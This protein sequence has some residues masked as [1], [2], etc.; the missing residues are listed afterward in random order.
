MLGRICSV[1]GLILLAGCVKHGSTYQFDPSAIRGEAEQAPPEEAPVPP[2][3]KLAAQ[4]E[5]DPPVKRRRSPPPKDEPLPDFEVKGNEGAEWL[6]A[7]LPQCEIG[8]NRKPCDTP[9]ASATDEQKKECVTLCTAAMR[10]GA[11]RVIKSALDECEKQALAHPPAAPFPACQFEFPPGADPRGDG[12]PIPAEKLSC[13]AACKEVVAERRNSAKERDRA[14][15]Q[16]EKIVTA[17]KKC[18]MAVDSTLEARKYEAYDRE[19]Y[20]QLMAKTEAK[21]RG[22]HKCDWL[23]QHSTEWQCAYGN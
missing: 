19:L 11:E 6:K 7:V 12:K 1:V 16:G 5:D 13:V 15:A 2:P 20:D 17:Y 22:A 9:P 21:C 4:E 23:E 8:M 14:N 18:M 10:A 3:A